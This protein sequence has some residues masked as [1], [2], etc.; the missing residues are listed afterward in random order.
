MWNDVLLAS[1]AFL[2]PGINQILSSW[3]NGD[4]S[5]DLRGR[6]NLRIQSRLLTLSNLF[7]IKS[8][9]TTFSSK[10]LSP[11]DFFFKRLVSE[12]LLS[13]KQIF[14]MNICREQTRP[15]FWRFRCCGLKWQW[16][17]PS[18]AYPSRSWRWSNSATFLTVQVSTDMWENG[19]Q[20]KMIGNFH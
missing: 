10:D 8:L 9:R 12:R 2:R 20:K 19:K 6:E 17:R 4:T 13:L 11:N 3:Q 7:V 1:V 14:Q 18:V 5:V 16:R 15:R